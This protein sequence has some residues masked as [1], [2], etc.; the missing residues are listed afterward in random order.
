M[1]SFDSKLKQ[2]TIKF[3]E[4]CFFDENNKKNQFFKCFKE[5]DIIKDKKI[6]NL[7]NKTVD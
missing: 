2:K 4:I 1:P 5:E 6:S 7:L 3:N